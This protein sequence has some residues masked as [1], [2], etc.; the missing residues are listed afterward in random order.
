MHTNT[1]RS[2]STPGA[3]PQDLSASNLVRLPTVLTMTGLGRTAWLDLVRAGKAPKAVKI[4]R[5]ALW[6][7][8][9][10]RGFIADRIRAS[11]GVTK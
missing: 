6:V 10:V 3:S 9:E 4:G 7:E 5:A 1:D 11:R 2:Q 8:A